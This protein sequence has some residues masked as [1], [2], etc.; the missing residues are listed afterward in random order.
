MQPFPVGKLDTNDTIYLISPEARK[1]HLAIFGK[2]GVGKTTLLRNMIAWDMDCG[3]GVTV[4]DPHGSLINDLLDLIPRSR[5]NDVIYFSP[6]ERRTVPGIN[7]MERVSAEY[8]PLV[9]S[10]LIS[11]LKNIWPD[12]WGP[13][14]DLILSSFAFALLEQPEPTTLLALH[15]LLT[16][17][18]YRK[19]VAAHV[20]DPIIR[21]FF[22]TYEN[23]WD[24]DKRTNASAPPLN[25]IAKLVTNPLLRDVVG[26]HTSSFDFRWMMDSKKILLCDL[27]KGAL[28][29]DVSSL[30][31]SLIVTKLFL[32]ALSRQDIPEAERIPHFFYIDEVHNFTYGIDL[33][34]ILSEA[35]QYRL[36]L[37]D[38]TQTLN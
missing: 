2:S 21:S 25:K 13:Q 17:P 19:H 10:A 3:L 12:G 15:K 23:E 28:G 18:D 36:T 4:I 14:T 33:A 20:T 1:R 27:S 16:R 6:Q 31:G 26:Q 5:T 38:A 37:T 35:R 9:V 34:S 29:E 30:L 8:R 32:A 22:D 11:T 7:I 24:D